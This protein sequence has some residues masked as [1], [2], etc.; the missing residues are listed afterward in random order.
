MPLRSRS[1]LVQ[2]AVDVNA[3]DQD[4]YGAVHHVIAL[5]KQ[6]MTT[7]D[8]LEMLDLLLKAGS[9]TDG[10]CNVVNC[11]RINALDLAH[12]CGAERIAQKLIKSCKLKPTTGNHDNA[13]ALSGDTWNSTDP[14]IS[15]SQV[16]EDSRKMLEILEKRQD[17]EH[18]G[19]RATMRDST[20]E[21]EEDMEV[22]DSSDSD[23][24][25]S[26]DDVDDGIVNDE[27]KKHPGCI[28]KDGFIYEGHTVIMNK[29]DVKYGAW[30][31][32]NYYRM[33]VRK[34]AI[35][36]GRYARSFLLILI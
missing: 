23:S 7:Y 10:L 19:K 29:I 22:D 24:D 20:S 27:E 9:P 25:A 28:V 8:N 4:G 32:Y 2:S 21:D 35:F 3:V 30:G 15:E 13:T 11:G 31:M 33:Q 1:S 34:Y 36:H 6:N 14:A 16:L 26:D 18:K 5:S 17:R 12:I